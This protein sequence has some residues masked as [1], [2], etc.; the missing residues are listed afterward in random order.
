MTPMMERIHPISTMARSDPTIHP[1][2]Y[3]SPCKKEFAA[4]VLPLMAFSSCLIS[5]SW[6]TSGSSFAIAL[7]RHTDDGLQEMEQQLEAIDE[8]IDDQGGEL[9]EEA[10]EDVQKLV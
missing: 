4:S 6:R 5:R 2:P 3:K 8:E 10:Q 1:A 9:Q 7:A